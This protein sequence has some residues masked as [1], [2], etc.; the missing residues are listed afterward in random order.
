MAHH[1]TLHRSGWTSYLPSEY[2]PAGTLAGFSESGGRRLKYALIRK[3]RLSLAVR[4][5]LGFILINVAAGLTPSQ[6]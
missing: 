1:N 6:R 3:Q 5:N 4:L 2:A